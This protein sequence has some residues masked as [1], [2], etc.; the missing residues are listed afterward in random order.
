METRPEPRCPVCLAPPPE[1]VACEACEEPFEPFRSAGACPRCALVWPRLACAC[2]VWL[3]LTR[4][5]PAGHA[6]GALQTRLEG[7]D[8]ADGLKVA[9]IRWLDLEGPVVPAQLLVARATLLECEEVLER[10][11]AGQAELEGL[12]AAAGDQERGALQR[13]RAASQTA[14]EKA[15]VALVEA[16]RGAEMLG[17][18]ALAAGGEA[19]G[20]AGRPLVLPPGEAS[21]AEP[22]GAAR[23]LDGLSGLWAR[24]RA[25]LR[26]DD[27]LKSFLAHDWPAVIAECTALLER[28][29]ERARA[30]VHRGAARRHLGERAAARADLERGLAPTGSQAG[31][32]DP[33]KA[34]ALCERAELRLGEGEA[35]AAQAEAAEAEALA[36]ATWRPPWLQAW[37]RIEQ[38]ERAAALADLDRALARADDEARGWLLAD[39][40]ALQLAREEWAAVETD[41][42]AAI[43]AEHLT[44]ALFLHRASARLEL[45]R[46]AEGEADATR[47]LRLAPGEPLGWLVRAWARLRQGAPGAR[48]DLARL[49]RRDP[50]GERSGAALPLAVE[51][52]LSGEPARAEALLRSAARA[53]PRDPQPQP[54]GQAAW[55]ELLGASPSDGWAAALGRFQRGELT[56]AQL[57]GGARSTPPSALDPEAL[58][59]RLE[60][61]AALREEGAIGP[62][63]L[64]AQKERLLGAGSG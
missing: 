2:G 29:P 40:A 56:A 60:R 27:G 52:W 21:G 15:R 46:A 39:R 62:D 41:A 31:L 18:R 13:A 11:Q 42:S 6:R 25:A 50:Q 16:R 59:G 12:A 54:A 35:A 23:L 28:Q 49:R 5:L 32:S 38:G 37:A 1:R 51:A 45:G 3:P 4:W 10:A 9:A 55:L 61:L 48:E 26:D 30:W 24:G 44:G 22:Q 14:L 17:R 33:L 64:A 63:E 43:A 19:G 58:V 34:W 8:P 53:E 57:L 47:A 7:R 36:P 20:E